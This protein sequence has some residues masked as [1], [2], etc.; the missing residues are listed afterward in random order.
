[1]NV[2]NNNRHADTIK[3]V[4]F[5]FIYNIIQYYLIDTSIMAN[6]RYFPSKGTTNDVGGIISTTKRK[7]T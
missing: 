3:N 7:N 1:M 4:M 2:Q 5:N 6:I